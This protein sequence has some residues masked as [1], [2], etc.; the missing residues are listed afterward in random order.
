VETVAA[1]E[2]RIEFQ[3]DEAVRINITGIENLSQSAGVKRRMSRLRLWQMILVP[4]GRLAAGCSL[5]AGLVHLLV[6]F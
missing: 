1:G 6:Q 5:A 2:K 4:P 3:R